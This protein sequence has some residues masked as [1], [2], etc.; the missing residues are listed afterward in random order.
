MDL[1]HGSGSSK[2]S[3]SHPEAIDG[4]G[5]SD[6]EDTYPKLR[7]R[8]GNSDNLQRDPEKIDGTESSKNSESNPQIING[9]VSSKQREFKLEFTVTEGDRYMPFVK[10]GSSSS[11]PSSAPSLSSSS[12]SLYDLFDVITKESS[13]PGA[14]TDFESPNKPHEITQPAS[15]DHE[16]DTSIDNSHKSKECEGGS[17]DHTLTFPVSDVNLESLVHDMSPTQSPPVQVMERPGGYD[18][19]RIP[20]SIFES[21]KGP[22]PMDWSVASNESLFS[23]HVGNNSFSRDHVLLFGDLGLSGDITQSGELIMFSP[24]PPKAMVATD[25]Q[26][27]DPAMGTHKQKGGA[28]GVADNT[29]KDPAEFK[30]EENKPSQAVSWKS[31]RTSGDSVESFSFP[32]LANGLINGSLKAGTE[33]R[34]LESAPAPVSQKSDSY[35]WCRC[36]SCCSWG[37][38]FNC[39]CSCRKIKCCC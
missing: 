21:N 7:V 17:S 10:S 24:P 29:I 25:N 8:V 5:T 11:S 32:I 30:N 27:S 36:F 12:S 19:F 15:Q 33:Q 23:I 3:E 1:E 38:S 26:S 31:P 16:N 37:C 6:H 4:R 18:P 28:N 22:A 2:H 35:H 34:H 20:S 13:D 14:C 39:C 9:S